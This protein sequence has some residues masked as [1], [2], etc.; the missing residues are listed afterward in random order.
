MS[1]ALKLLR[2]KSGDVVNMDDLNHTIFHAIGHHVVF[3]HYQ[4]TRARHPTRPA[5]GWELRQQS[6]FVFDLSHERPR[7]HGVVSGDVSSDGIQFGQ[8]S[9][10]PLISKFDSGSGLDFG[11]CFNAGLGGRADFG[12]NDRTWQIQH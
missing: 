10:S 11:A 5:N 1:A 4:L 12:I 7:T 2:P 6:G 8:C 9:A 3:V